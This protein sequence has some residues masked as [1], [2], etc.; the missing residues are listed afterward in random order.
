MDEDSA[1]RHLCYKAEDRG[2]PPKLAVAPYRHPPSAASMNA[3]SS[4]PRLGPS[5]L[6][7]F[8]LVTRAP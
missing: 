5:T 1:T 8:A 6:P 4:R 7:S 3:Q 2:G